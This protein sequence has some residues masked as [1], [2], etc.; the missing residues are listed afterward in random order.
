MPG[1]GG[2]PTLRITFDL[3][4]QLDALRQLYRDE[5][6]RKF[7]SLVRP[8]QAGRSLFPRRE[9]KKQGGRFVPPEVLPG[10]SMLK[11]KAYAVLGNAAAVSVQVDGQ[12]RE[13]PAAAVDGEGARFIVNRSGTLARS[14][15]PIHPSPRGVNKAWRC[16]MR[17]AGG[18][19]RTNRKFRR[20][21]R[22]CGWCRCR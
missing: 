17:S 18:T 2:L 9:W 13:I 3:T 19:R 22:A 7:D 21:C 16:A 5:W 11:W 1:A 4:A 6:L 20:R 15:C 14:R 8:Q 10:P 12:P